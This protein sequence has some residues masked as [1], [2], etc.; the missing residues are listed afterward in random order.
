MKN[1]II[2]I[3]LM[4]PV[5]S[6]AQVKK[7]FILD[8]AQ[9]NKYRINNV[10]SDSFKIEIINKI[11][12]KEY[13]AEIE[14][15]T[16]DIRPLATDDFKN[17][18]NSVAIATAAKA[19]SDSEVK[20]LVEQIKNVEN[21]SELK[22][23][24]IKL[25]QQLSLAGCTQAIID[26]AVNILVST[27]KTV[28][29][30]VVQEREKLKVKIKREDNDKSWNAVITGRNYNEWITTFGF[31]FVNIENKTFFAK[32]TGV[33]SFA[34]IQDPTEK[35]KWDYIPTIMFTYLDNMGESP[36]FFW[37]ISGG[38]GFDLKAPSVFLGL[39]FVYHKNLVLTTGGVM[40]QQKNLKGKYKVGEIVSE[41]L[42]DDQLHQ[43][44]YKPNWFVSLSFRLD[45][46]PFK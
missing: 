6:N 4:L 33:D 44:I 25:K 37:G 2:A 46:N 34:I 9:K 42:D 22:G 36:R 15:F 30:G 14:N 16:N 13:V 20:K 3:L 40:H 1:I 28:Y 18:S 29:E 11:P 7:T 32:K 41:P 43:K 45:K 38:L 31:S 35:R 27:R 24:I 12:L 8:L 26:G 21:E 10:G 19:C 5:L 39:S 23:L 17:V